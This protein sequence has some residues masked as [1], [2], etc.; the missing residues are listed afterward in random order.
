[1]KETKEMKQRHE[2][3]IDKEQVVNLNLRNIYTYVSI[4]KGDNPNMVEIEIVGNQKI[5]TDIQMDNKAPDSPNE[6]TING[7][8]K[9][10]YFSEILT[11]NESE[12]PT[13]RI[14]IPS[15]FNLVTYNVSRLEMSGVTANNLCLSL[16]Y[17]N[18]ATID[19]TIYQRCT[20]NCKNTSHFSLKDGNN[21][22]KLTTSNNSE[23][24]FDGTF[25]D[26]NIESADKSIFRGS[27]KTCRLKFIFGSTK[28]S[29]FN[30]MSSYIDYDDYPAPYDAREEMMQQVITDKPLKED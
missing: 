6:I 14:K 25:E 8:Y 22:F 12:T 7:T 13:V 27:G 28:A 18:A 24:D 26:L 19:Q 23:A 4:E 21:Y 10:I 3:E 5:F 15:T 20:V 2:F 16:I 17:D 9:R 30:V 1:M 29:E 11:K